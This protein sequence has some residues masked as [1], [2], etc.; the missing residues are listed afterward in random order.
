MKVIQE[1]VAHFE[2]QNKL[3]PEEIKALLNQGLLA[4]E[5]PARIQDLC[6]T[7][8][9]TYYFRVTGATDGSVWGT[10]VYT[11]DSALA[12]AAVHAG[13]IKPGETAVVRVT[14]MPP[15]TQ[16]HGSVRN[17]VTSHDFGRFGAA[18]RVDRL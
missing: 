5:A 10:D 18:Y 6:E 11:G 1:L 16:Y 2:R 17:G 4:S 8:G 12:V 13:A 9:T 7:P 15:V 14:V 3:T